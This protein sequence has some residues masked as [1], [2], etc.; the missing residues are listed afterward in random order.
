MVQ[1]LHVKLAFDRKAHDEAKV[2]GIAQELWH[3]HFG[4]ARSRPHPNMIKGVKRK[5]VNF[6]R[7]TAKK[8]KLSE[9]GFL[10]RRHTCIE[11][12]VDNQTQ[13]SSQRCAQ[14]LNAIVRSAAWDETQH[15]V[16]LKKQEDAMK[17]RRLE[18]LQQGMLLPNEISMDDERALMKEKVAERK[19]EKY[20][21][22]QERK[23]GTATNARRFDICAFRGSPFRI[24]GVLDT[25]ALRARC[26]QVG[27]RA[28]SRDDVFSDVYIVGDPANMGRRITMK[29]GALGAF[30]ITPATLDGNGCAVKHKSAM[31]IP[32]LFLH[33]AGSG[34]ST[35]RCGA[36]CS[37]SSTGKMRNGRSWRVALP[38]I[39]Q[40]NS[41]WRANPTTRR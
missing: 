7:S 4:Q 33:P 9:A 24:E 19:R 35:L 10:R 1:L 18:A 16:V 37:S 14:A 34:E 5:L 15:G 6:C 2:L 29:A 20:R 17:K 26:R 27:M 23:R 21:S 28:S 36:S 11:D 41:D 40:A 3:T 25:P 38:R 39:S 8:H 30:V 22:C 31:R 13:E 32:K 12:A